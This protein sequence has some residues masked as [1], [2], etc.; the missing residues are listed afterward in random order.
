MSERRRAQPKLHHYV[1]QFYLE[2]FA[3][4]G[5][6]FWVFDKRNE[7]TFQTKPKAIAAETNFYK[8]SLLEN[9]S[10]A[11]FIENALSSIEAAAAAIT[12]KWLVRLP[13]MRPKE[14]LR[15]SEAHRIDFSLFIAVQWLRTVGTRDILT[16]LLNEN[17]Q[18]GKGEM[19]TVHQSFLILEDLMLKKFAEKIHNAIW[20]FGRNATGVPFVTSDNPV[21]VHS[22]NHMWLRWG[23]PET[24]GVC[25]TLPLSDS[26]IFFAYERSYWSKFMSEADSTVSPIAFTYELVNHENN[27]QVCNAARFVISP[28]NDFDFARGLLA[29]GYT[30]IVD[31]AIHPR[32]TRRRGTSERRL[33][34]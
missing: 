33:G 11:L 29:E 14:R 28:K 34:R 6:R 31:P 17:G 22:P 19:A 1:P 9:T 23:V 12:E 8:S 10:H 24:P 27:G 32:P 20:M 7:Q 13:R 3:D 5:G 16:H 30:A 15:I 4:D 18:Y 2:R 21:T 26:M 25:I